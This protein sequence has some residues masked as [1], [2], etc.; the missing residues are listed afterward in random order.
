MD[1]AGKAAGMGILGRHEPGSVGNAGGV[2]CGVMISC[3][4]E[5]ARRLT[6]TTSFPLVEKL[7]EVG[8][9]GRGVHNFIINLFPFLVHYVP[10]TT[11]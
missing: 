9:C 2:N 5:L 1:E 3:S 7:G 4:L 6:D 11:D 8:S 10:I